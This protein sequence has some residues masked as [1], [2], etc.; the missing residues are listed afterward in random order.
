MVAYDDRTVNLAAFAAF[1]KL[2]DD[3][4]HSE[5]R[6]KT[7]LTAEE[8]NSFLVLLREGGPYLPEGV[9]EACT[10][11]FEAKKKRAIKTSE[12]GGGVLLTSVSFSSTKDSDDDGDLRRTVD[13]VA[14]YVASILRESEKTRRVRIYYVPVLGKKRGCPKARP[15]C[16]GPVEAPLSSVDVNSG[17][18]LGSGDSAVVLIYRKQE[19]AK[20]AVHELLHAFGLDLARKGAQKWDRAGRTLAER[21]NVRSS[22]PIRLNEAYTETVASFMH[23][24]VVAGVGGIERQRLEEM[25]VHFLNQA[26]KIM[27]MMMMSGFRQATHAFEYYIVKAALFKN[28]SATE[29][30]ELLDATK[31]STDMLRLLVDDADAYMASVSCRLGMTRL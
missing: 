16:R 2:H 28:R 20:V 3:D 24:A 7:L 30:M 13:T 6:R 5:T 15:G 31:K 12:H 9:V 4:V 10:A 27:C 23:E 17:V 25:R 19:A 8:D 22:V 14:A 21:W 11:L 1:S 29:V 26:E 18:T